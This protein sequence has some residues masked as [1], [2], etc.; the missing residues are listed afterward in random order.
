MFRS[1]HS[2]IK[3]LCWWWKTCQTHLASITRVY[4]Y[5]LSKQACWSMLTYTWFILRI[6]KILHALAQDV[7]YGST[8]MNRTLYRNN[9]LSTT[10]QCR[11]LKLNPLS[12]Q[13][14]IYC[15]MTNQMP[16]LLIQHTL[17][18]RAAVITVP[19]FFLPPSP[20]SYNPNACPLSTF[21]NQ[22]GHH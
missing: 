1:Y 6:P 7:P 2:L 21:E 17:W 12:T 19:L 15:L 4:K 9:N 8:I 13:I 14:N 16:A 5:L 3:K 22:D 18:T 10:C 11:Q 20:Y